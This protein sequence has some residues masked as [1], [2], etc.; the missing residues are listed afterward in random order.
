[1]SFLEIYRNLE[2]IAV[3]NEEETRKHFE[4]FNEKYKYFLPE[5]GEVYSQFFQISR[6]FLA[7]QEL[8]PYNKYRYFEIAYKALVFF[9]DRSVEATLEKFDNF[10]ERYSAKEEF[11]RE[12]D[13]LEIDLPYCIDYGRM[14][15]NLSSWKEKLLEFGPV[16]MKHASHLSKVEQHLGRIAINKK[17]LDDWLTTVHYQRASE[18][19]NLARLAYAYDLEEFAFNFL[20]DNIGKKVLY[21]HA[22]LPEIALDIKAEVPKY[23]SEEL[24]RECKEISR[25]NDVYFPSRLGLAEN[26]FAAFD[27]LF[28]V[29]LPKDDI[30]YKIFHAK[31]FGDWD[32]VNPISEGIY[33][34]I[35]A[36]PQEAF[37][38]NNIDWDN[39]ERLGHKIRVKYHLSSQLDGVI[40][41]NQSIFNYKTNILDTCAE[42]LFTSINQQMPDLKLVTR[43]F[44]IQ[45]YYEGE[46]GIA[47]STIYKSNEIALAKYELKKSGF[48]IEKSFN[49]RSA[50]HISKIEELGTEYVNSLKYKNE[51][52]SWIVFKECSSAQEVKELHKEILALQESDSTRF[53]AI[54]NLGDT[55][56]ASEEIGYR[57]LASYSTEILKFLSTINLPKYHL[58]LGNLVNGGANILDVKRNFVKY[59]AEATHQDGDISEIVEKASPEAIDILFQSRSLAISLRYIKLQDIIGLNAE[60]LDQ[61]LSV[62]AIYLYTNGVDYKEFIGDDDVLALKRDMFI[63]TLRLMIREDNHV[64]NL[65]VGLV[66]SIS[67]FTEGQI[68]FLDNQANDLVKLLSLVE[69]IAQNPAA[70]DRILQRRLAEI[71]LSKFQIVE[72]GI[73]QNIPD[74]KFNVIASFVIEKMIQA[75]YFTIEALLPH[76]ASIISIISSSWHS[77]P[78]IRDSFNLIEI[79]ECKDPEFVLEILKCQDVKLT[80]RE[81]DEVDKNKL[82]AAIFDMMDHDEQLELLS[83]EVEAIE[84]AK[85]AFFSSRQLIGANCLELV[86]ISDIAKLKIISS[87]ARKFIEIG[88][89]RQLGK[90]LLE[91]PIEVI[92]SLDCSLVK[93]FVDKQHSIEG[94]IKA[95]TSKS[96]LYS[97]LLIEYVEKFEGT[98]EFSEKVSTLDYK[99][100]ERLAWVAVCG[101]DSIFTLPFLLKLDES[102]IEPIIGC[103]LACENFEQVTPE[104]L[105]QYSGEIIQR[106]QG[107]HNIGECIKR[108]VN[109]KDL[110]EF[111]KSKFDILMK[112]YSS[113]ESFFASGGTIQ[114]L[115]E[116]D[117]AK[118]EALLSRDAKRTYEEGITPSELSSY[119][120]H[121][122][123]LVTSNYSELGNYVKAG[124][125][126]VT[127]AECEIT[128]AECILKHSRELEGFV[129]AGGDIQILL[130]LE[131]PKIEALFSFWACSAYRS[132]ILN[133]NQLISYEAD[134][135]IKLTDLRLH[136]EYEQGKSIEFVAHELFADDISLAGSDAIA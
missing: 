74:D 68:D 112:S 96:D 104:F 79:L 123:K 43:L 82:R 40:I 118:I 50:D 5:D 110:A 86:R 94:L 23:I 4:F 93:F 97:R 88:L 6:V 105:S 37:D 102:Q 53:K 55:L 24:G 39:L 41:F 120:V 81:I 76:E 75:G 83:Y 125:Q 22:A 84:A 91:L 20:L 61:I 72:E 26:G 14:H 128:Q 124:G 45:D 42:I 64:Q 54:F 49:Y 15:F 121:F 71:E 46:R 135:I 73:L 18:N 60:L 58:K 129:K 111:D 16:I 34:L 77:S 126:L 87:L 8:L 29:N 95:S 80:P 12:S 127:L 117:A 28:L 2:D 130:Q 78:R 1:M 3:L 101:Q 57:T 11:R 136:R 67:K 17:E 113:L 9:G 103:E 38:P 92:Q 114:S 52:L 98:S 108:G 70:E 30:R 25:Y 69:F 21:P 99:I 33:V 109:P 131:I 107:W 115:V 44:Y 35:E 119:D 62:P 19:P 31:D 13:L 7:K 89:D 65:S 27:D 116:L 90:Y 134:Q 100:L 47:F 32:Y 59:V 63:S 85:I 48:D 56:L 36:N 10:I 133:P 132:S 106:F 51:L 66:S 122:I